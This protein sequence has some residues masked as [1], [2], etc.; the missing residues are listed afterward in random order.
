M[1]RDLQP[2]LPIPPAWSGSLAV[3]R[4]VLSTT[5]TVSWFV[6]TDSKILHFFY[7][8]N[9]QFLNM[10]SLYTLTLHSNDLNHLSFLLP[11]MSICPPKNYLSLSL[12]SSWTILEPKRTKPHK[13]DPQLKSIRLTRRN[14]RHFPFDKVRC[15]FAHL[16][17]FLDC[18]SKWLWSLILYIKHSKSE[19]D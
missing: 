17:I 5:T 2:R 1:V 11:Y 16:E 19:A 9:M 3:A 14:T 8:A 4:L 18:C 15:S 7:I 12:L 13:K 10:H 6:K